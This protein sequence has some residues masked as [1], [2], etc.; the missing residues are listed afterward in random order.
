MLGMNKMDDKD[1]RILDQKEKDARIWFVDT[2]MA[3]VDN[4][5]LDDYEFRQFVRCS[6]TLFTPIDVERN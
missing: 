6:V 3:N 2:L 4:T 1:E 5:N